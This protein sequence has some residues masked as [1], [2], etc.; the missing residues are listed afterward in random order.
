MIYLIEAG[1]ILIELLFGLASGLFVFRVLLQL[2]GAN[3]YNPI[4]QFVFQ[5][6][7]PLLVP[8]RRWLRPVGRFEIGGS[9]IAWL[10]QVIKVWLLA[11][12]LGASFGIAGLLLLGAVELLSLLLYLYF[13]L[14]LARALLSFISVDRRHPILPLLAQLT[15]P[16]LAP[17]RRVLPTTGMIDL[18][19][20][21][22]MLLLVLARVLVVA[23]L[24]DLGRALALG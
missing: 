23:P 9:L 16:L 6:T 12:L 4:C 19:P 13:W 2:V 24:T 14:I 11:L 18:S 17:L 15:E 3:F 5:A 1:A 20:M 8:L 21:L 10:L 7:N 22:V